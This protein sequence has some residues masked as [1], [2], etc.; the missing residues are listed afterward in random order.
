MHF[1]LTVPLF[2]P[3]PA[4]GEKQVHAQFIHSLFKMPFGTIRP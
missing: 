1:R 4:R 3:R 2:S